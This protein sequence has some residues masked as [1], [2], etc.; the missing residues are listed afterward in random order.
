MIVHNIAHLIFLSLLT[1]NRPRILMA[2]TR[3]PLSLLISMM[4]RT[5]SYNMAWPT[6]LPDSVL[7]ATY[8]WH[9]SIVASHELTWANMSFICSLQ[10]LSPLPSILSNRNM[11]TYHMITTLSSHDHYTTRLP[12]RM[13]HWC[14][15]HHDQGSILTLSSSLIYAP[16]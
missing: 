14:H 2:R 1:K 5:V 8:N 6:F 13:G 11:C 10:S 12:V 15:E 9:Y 4:V 3:N 7:V 16:D